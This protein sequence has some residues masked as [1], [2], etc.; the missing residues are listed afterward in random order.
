MTEQDGK[1]RDILLRA[2]SDLEADTFS[3]QWE[4]EVSLI[5]EHFITIGDNDISEKYQLNFDFGE[6]DLDRLVTAGYFEKTVELN[7]DTAVVIN[8]RLK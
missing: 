3:Y 6:L 8:Y 7:T 4:W 5:P 1:L 2:L